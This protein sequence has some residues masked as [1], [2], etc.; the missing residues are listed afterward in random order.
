[1]YETACGSVLH[2]SQAALVGRLY[3]HPSSCWDCVTQHVKGA[4]RALEYGPA[5]GIAERK[6]PFTPCSTSLWEL[7]IV[8]SCAWL[9]QNVMPADL[10]CI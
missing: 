3:C 7:C 8:G 9:R 1:M 10:L 4:A 6:G 5:K 2:I